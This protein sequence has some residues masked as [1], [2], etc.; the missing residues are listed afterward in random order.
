MPSTVTLSPRLWH[1]WM[2]DCA[3]AAALGI[4]ALR[5]HGYAVKTLQEHHQQIT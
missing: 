3:K 2:Q 5:K 1:N 4:A